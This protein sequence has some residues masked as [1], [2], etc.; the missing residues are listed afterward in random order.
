MRGRPKS[1]D[2]DM[3]LKKILL[4]FWEHGYTGTNYPMLCAATQLEKP[5]LYNAF[6]NKEA[7]FKEA[8]DL[9]VALAI[10][11]S[12]EAFDATENLT[13]ALHNLLTD[14]VDGLTDPD[15]PSGCFI[16]SNLASTRNPNVPL[17]LAQALETAA[18]LTSNAIGERL[19]RSS[20]HERPEGTDATPL[21][22]YFQTLIAGLSMLAYSGTPRQALY[23]VIDLA[24]APWPRPS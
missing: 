1:F 18:D 11:P 4:T 5:S 21:A 12:L 19:A 16:A 6:G 9:Y 15:T 14:I 8:L 20:P 22:L 2:R 24:M 10:R 13:Q 7:L 3:T 23:G 17:D